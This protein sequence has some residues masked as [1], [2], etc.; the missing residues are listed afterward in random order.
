M[1][2]FPNKKVKEW[3]AGWLSESTVNLGSSSQSASEKQT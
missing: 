1:K 3:L 2:L